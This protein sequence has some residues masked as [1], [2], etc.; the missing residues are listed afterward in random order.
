MTR[1]LLVAAALAAAAALSGCSRETTCPVGEILCAGRCVDP[2]S[3]AA[4]CGACG[5]ACDARAACV[6]GACD[7]APVLSSCGGACVDLASDPAHCGA[8]GVACFGG[9]VC[10]AA[11]GPAVCTA[12]CGAGEANCGGA[13]VRLEEDRY[14]CG[15]CGRSCAAGESCEG[16]ACTSLQVACFSTNEVRA[17]APDLSS[18]G[19]VRPAGV[20]PIALATLG[21]DVWAAASLSGS[22]VRLP[23]ALG[24]PTEYLL[25]GKDFEAVTTHAGRILIASAGAGTVVV[26]D[27]ATGAA[28]DEVPV[29]TSAADNVRG[30]AFAD[31]GAGEKAY[32]TLYGNAVTGD[33]AVGQRVVV[34]DAA[35]LAACGVSAG[36]GHCLTPVGAI[37]VSAGADA[38]GLAFPGRAVAFGGKVYVVIAN[39]KQSFGFYGTPAGPGRLA[40]ID[41]ATDTATFLSLGDACGNPGGAA[42]RGSTLWVACGA[43][44]AGGLVEVD[45]SGA[46]PAVGEVRALPLLAPGNVAFCGS[47]GF[48]TDQFSGDVYP[49][50]PMSFSDSPPSAATICPTSAGP[51]GYAWAA[52]VA[53]AI[54]P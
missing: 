27:P 2:A 35:G 21:A 40:V 52:D 34:L 16:G 15:A 54:D 31:G 36:P 23:A 44:G 10:S 30:I 22:L 20:G 17:V 45:L 32:V 7:C 19:P 11:G 53:C 29:G 6:R 49:F 5:I 28:V 42:L 38:P 14:H 8:C 25:H 43:F 4:N 13:C 3:D 1:S 50:D 26:V 51:N 39:L 24:A 12:A 48:V 18:R 37:D 9:T 47:R 33:P 46:A 41:P